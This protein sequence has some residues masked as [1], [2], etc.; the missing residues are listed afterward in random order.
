MVKWKIVPYMKD[1]RNS[2]MVQLLQSISVFSEAAAFHG[3]IPEVDYVVQ[4]PTLATGN[5]RE[6]G[7]AGNG[8]D[9]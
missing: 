8:P 1:R 2:I 9:I 3:D 6:L 7:S 5:R 4:L